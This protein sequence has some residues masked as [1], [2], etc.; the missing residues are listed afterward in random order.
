MATVTC[1]PGP[2]GGVE[3]IG[4]GRVSPSE[5]AVLIAAIA[6]AV[7][8]AHRGSGQPLPVTGTQVEA[9]IAYAD[10]T[11]VGLLP[12][13]PSQDHCLLTL[14]FG[15][16]VIGIAIPNADARRLGETL[17]AASA[18]VGAPH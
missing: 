1:E 8:Q 6:S 13:E 14:H 4:S 12:G 5:A 9:P 17:M 10:I 11:A 7:T 16:A 3:I 2:D 15:E 18:D